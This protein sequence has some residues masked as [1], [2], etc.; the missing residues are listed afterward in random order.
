MAHPVYG[1]HVKI[2]GA[3]IVSDALQLTSLGGEYRF[4]RVFSTE[5]NSL[6]DKVTEN[7]QEKLLTHQVCRI[8]GRIAKECLLMLTWYSRHQFERPQHTKRSQRFD[9]EYL[10]VSDHRQKDANG[11]AHYTPQLLNETR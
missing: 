10:T 9:V 6:Q 2:P 11:S 5:L 4:L 1:P 7:H 3:A 8:S